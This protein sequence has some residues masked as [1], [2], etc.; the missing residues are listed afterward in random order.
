MRL[1]PAGSV[2]VRVSVTST[3]PLVLASSWSGPGV[4]FH[5]DIAPGN[6]LLDDQGSLSAV[7]DFG[8]CGVG[9][10]ACDLVI[11]W[12]LLRGPA[13]DAFRA[14]VGLDGPTWAR[15]R[16]WALWKALIVLAA[17]PDDPGGNAAVIAEVLADHEA[18]GDAR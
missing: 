5:G 18:A 9:D 6:L 12:T 1:R 13:R 16:G 17:D 2:T 15:A 4:W 7:L 3:K 11:T 8:T 14:G 10:P